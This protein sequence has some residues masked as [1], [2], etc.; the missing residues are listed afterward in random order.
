MTATFEYSDSL[1]IDCGQEDFVFQVPPGI[2]SKAELI[3][4]LADVGR[5]PDYFG[6]NWDALLDCLRDLS[7]IPNKRV[8]IVHSDVPVLDN[9]SE[10]RTYL[11]I[12]RMVLADWSEP[13]KPDVAEPPPEWTYV[14]HEL[15][16]VFPANA[17]T[18]IESLMET[19]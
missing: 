4:T 9:S 7:W 6:N 18:T 12:L 1:Q 13:V 8:V 11:D 10:C 3:S 15:T 5:F 2:R 17:R 16:I 14:E 19:K